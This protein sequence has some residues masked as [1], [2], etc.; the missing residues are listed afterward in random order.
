[1]HCFLLHF[2]HNSKNNKKKRTKNI[3][4]PFDLPA[5][6]AEKFKSQLMNI[7]WFAH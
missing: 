6:L 1:M 3:K 7:Y 5:I 2:F 4:D